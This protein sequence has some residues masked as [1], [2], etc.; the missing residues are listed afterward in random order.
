MAVNTIALV[1]PRE[2]AEAPPAALRFWEG[3][4]WGGFVMPKKPI[5]SIVYTVSLY[6][7]TVH[8]RSSYYEDGRLSGTSG[9]VVPIPAECREWKRRLT[10][11]IQYHDTLASA[12]RAWVLQ[13]ELF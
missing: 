11:M 9:Q 4:P 1:L 5:E 3:G 10:D 6:E 12:A 8:V 13:L 7:T 2:Q